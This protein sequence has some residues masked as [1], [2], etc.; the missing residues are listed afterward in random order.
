M[1]GRRGA[2]AIRR[3]CGAGRCRTD[4]AALLRARLAAHPRQLIPARSR[5]RT[6]EQVAL[7]V[8]NVEKGIRHRRHGW[9]IR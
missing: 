4:Q 5:C 2:G 7:F 1:S 9:R 8:A 6:P 3:G